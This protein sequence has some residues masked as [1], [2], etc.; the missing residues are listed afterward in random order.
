M[1]TQS[2]ISVIALVVLLT[3]SL[4]AGVIPGRWEKVETLGQG[5]EI[6]ITMKSGD[7]LEGAFRHPDAE[8]LFV[9]EVNGSERQ[10]PKREVAKVVRPLVK[11]DS[12]WDG[13]AIGAAIGY[14]GGWAWLAAM[15]SGG[16]DWALSDAFEV[17]GP[18]GAAAGLGIGFA[19]DRT[20]KSHKRHKG[21]EVLYQAP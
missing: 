8:A 18:I 2:F 20:H 10:I 12:S 19:I 9:V 21:T 11:G 1:K 15:K 5:A 6:I 14:G 3:T 4:Q 17:F 16:G 13:A 7:R